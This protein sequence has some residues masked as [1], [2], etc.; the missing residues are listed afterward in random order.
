MI[1]GLSRMHK[2]T[3]DGG[4]I[5]MVL[6][7][8]H[9][10]RREADTANQAHAWANE[11]RAIAADEG[12]S[13]G[14]GD[15]RSQREGN[16]ALGGRADGRSAYWPGCGYGVRPPEIGETPLSAAEWVYL[17]RGDL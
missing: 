2:S 11:C 7:D 10:L 1:N 14:L 17:F 8:V 12:G 4:Q 5:H 15:L 13:I 9:A 6:P 3:R 16:Q